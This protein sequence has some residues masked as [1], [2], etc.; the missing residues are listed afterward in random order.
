MDSHTLLANGKDSNLH[1]AI[2]W[3][4]NIQKDL[5]ASIKGD[6]FQGFVLFAISKTYKSWEIVIKEQANLPPHDRRKFLGKKSAHELV[7]R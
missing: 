4:L 1:I 2:L 6:G 5:T 3:L 7:N